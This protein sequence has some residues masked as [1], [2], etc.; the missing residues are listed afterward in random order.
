MADL[1]TQPPADSVAS[2]I[3]GREGER[4]GDESRKLVDL[5]SDVT[6]EPAAI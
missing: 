4:R 3:D 1:K 6:G 5:L 2:F